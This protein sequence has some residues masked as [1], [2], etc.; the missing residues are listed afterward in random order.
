MAAVATMFAACSE[1]DYVNEATVQDA[2]QAIG[3]ETFSN[4]TT[5]HSDLTTMNNYHTTF[6]V[7]G[8]N[9]TDGLFM[10]NY[11]VQYD[12]A[13]KYDNV[14]GQEM[15]YWDKNQTYNFYAYAPYNASVTINEGAFTIPGGDYAATENL[16]TTFSTTLNDGYFSSDTDW[17]LAEAKTNYS[18]TSGTTVA[19]SFKHMLS[20]FVVAV[21]TTGTEDVEIS[22]L[23]V[24]GG[25]YAKGSYDGTAWTA[26][27]EKS[28]TGVVGTVS[29]Q[30]TAYYSMEYLLI[31]TAT[32][33]PKLNI[34]YKVNGQTYTYTDLDVT[35]IEKFEAG[36]Y[37]TLT[38]S[39]GLLP[40]EFNASID[41]WSVN[42]SGSVT[43]E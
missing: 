19:L 32:A 16:Q 9:V 1:T 35:G 4:K 14:E 41:K 15:K 6:G 18:Y 27:E 43:I 33:T 7:Y 8:Y 40:I 42:T 20:K 11:K 2:P 31:P 13:W 34:T 10:T 5:R 24:T 38:V 37:Y 25:T 22:S 3:F 17:M 39:V 36:T 21:K 28:L 23:S 26:S 29:T 12:N 30:N